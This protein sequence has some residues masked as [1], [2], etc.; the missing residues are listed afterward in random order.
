[1]GEEWDTAE[2][3]KALAAADK[4]IHRPGELY[5]VDLV[6]LDDESAEVTAIFWRAGEDGHREHTPTAASMGRITTA[7]RRLTHQRRVHL[8][9]WWDCLGWSATIKREA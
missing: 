6:Q 8:L 2:L 3:G 1:M 9:P 7:I 4:R 5:R